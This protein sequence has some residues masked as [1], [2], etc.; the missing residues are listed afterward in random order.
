M[1]DRR[2]FLVDSGSVL[3]FMTALSAVGAAS[4]F[5]IS[6]ARRDADAGFVNLTAEEAADLEAVAGQII[7]TTDTPGAIEAGVIYFI[8]AA[9]TD[10][11]PFAPMLPVL[12]AGVTELTEKLR[13]SGHEAERF[14]AADAET[15]LSLLTEIEATPFFGMVS[16]LT[17]IGFFVDPEY[18]GNRD[19]IGWALI[20]FED[21]HAWQPPFGY[22]DEQLMSEE[23]DES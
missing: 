4:I 5:N 16:T 21:K 20:G 18:G 8:D 19:K 7:P 14:A 22:Y 6:C 13:E 11:M 1:K 9:V 17:K 23:G 15:M 10:G 12:Q 3:G 2:Q